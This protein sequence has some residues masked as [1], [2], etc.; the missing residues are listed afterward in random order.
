MS[1]SALRVVAHVMSAV[2]DLSEERLRK[3][4]ETRADDRSVLSLYLDLDPAQFA[5]AP[6]RATEIV[7][8]LDSA[9]REIER[10]E[11]SHSEQQ[12]LRAALARARELLADEQQPW[13]RGARSLALFVCE[14]LGLHDLLRLPHPVASAAVIGDVPFIAPLVETG[15]AGRICVA[16]IDERFARVLRGSAERLHEVVSFGDSVHG[17]HD[18]GGWSQARYQRS[19]HEEAESHLRHVGQVLHDLLRVAP[20]ERLLIACTEPLWPRVLH[21]LHQDVRSLV[22]ERR[23]TLDVGDAGIEDVVSAIEPVLAEERRAYEDALLERLR[24]RSGREDDGRAALGP[25]AVMHA[26]VERRVAALLY[27]SG[28]QLAGVVCLRCG[29]MGV[30]GKSCPVDGEQLQARANVLD[31]VVQAAIAQSAE[32]LALR[33]RPELGPMRGIAATLRF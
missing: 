3:L 26:L 29:W 11:R 10:D 13:A 5:T 33:D 25:Q 20:Y 4:A 27:E 32:V 6:A 2:N 9:H 24:A 1:G 15:A 8:L 21:A 23:L 16:L 28:L 18:Q 14:P 7:S 31:D 30:Q 19:Q 22:C 17:R 12:A